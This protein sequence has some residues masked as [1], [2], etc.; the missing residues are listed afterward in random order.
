MATLPSTLSQT[1]EGYDQLRR[2]FFN[3]RV[4]DI[5]P[6][7]IASPTTTA[8]VVAAVKRAREHGWKIG[9]RSGGHLFFCS[10]LLDGG[11]LID[12]RNLNQDIEYDP[13]TKVASISPGHKV[14]DV[15]K[16]LEA[17][18][19]FFPAG[20]SR[21]VA[22]GGFLLA[23][24]QGCFLRGWGY[25]ASNWVTQLEVVTSEGETVIA[26][27]GSGQG[28]FGVI[29][30]I[31]VST[32]P[33]RRLFDTTIIVDSTDIFKPL[34]KWVLE[35]SKKVPKYGVDLFY[36]TFYADKDDPNGGHESAAK[37]VFFAINETIFADSFDEAKVLA[38]PWNVVP[39]EF[40]KYIVTTVPLVER[41]W[42]ELWGLQE[43][44]QPQGNGER[45]N[46]D[47][48][49]VDP[50]ASDD[51]LIDAITPALYDLPSR[52]S[53]GT[54]CPMDYYPDEADQ[55]LSLPQKTY[56]STMCCWK[57]PKQDAAVDKWLLDAY[58][59]AEKVSCGVM[60][61]SALKKWLG[62]RSKWDPSETF[63][64]HR[65]FSSV[66]DSKADVGAKL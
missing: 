53:S 51:E 34:L 52:L 8:E 4:P 19:R 48:I 61:D 45:W 6:T 56:V 62:I 37:R 24:G 50:K 13:A 31:W 35:T 26:T 10:A 39:D 46:V 21:S 27:P 49:L 18:G 1:S 44:F 38:S 17:R 15:T 30:R 32:I 22:V 40:K 20:H 28:Y 14:A 58:T 63:I 59:K 5:H 29:T 36:C 23:G 47:S 11:L 60:T 43:S 9:V 65:G 57:D 33:T 3:Q 55:A 42:E 54:F 7:E 16:Y 12:T 25:T 66:L 41:T 2:K 64:G